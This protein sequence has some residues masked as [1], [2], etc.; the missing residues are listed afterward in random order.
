MP[1]LGLVAGGVEFDE[2]LDDGAGGE[3]EADYCAL[4]ACGDDPSFV[5]GISGWYYMS[6]ILGTYRLGNL[7]ISGTRAVRILIPSGTVHRL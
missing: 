1:L 3:G 4:P 7:G 5:G 6:L 2:G